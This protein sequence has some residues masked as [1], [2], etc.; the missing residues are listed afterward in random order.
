MPA[1]YM[2]SVEKA[3]SEESGG[4]PSIYCC[5]EAPWWR[6][7]ISCEIPHVARDNFFEWL[8][9]KVLKLPVHLCFSP[10]LWS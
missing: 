8:Y 10:Q 1:R 6:G 2:S 9:G 4:D 3:E 5:Q 7:E